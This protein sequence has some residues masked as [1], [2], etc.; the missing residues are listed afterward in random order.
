MLMTLN[1][2]VIGQ[3]TTC[4]MVMVPFQAYQ[5]C[6][7][8]VDFGNKEL[9][10]IYARQLYLR[11]YGTGFMQVHSNLI[12]A[13]RN[14]EESMLVNYIYGG[15]A[16]GSHKFTAICHCWKLAPYATICPFQTANLSSQYF[17]YINIMII[18]FIKYTKQR[19]H[20]P[21]YHRLEDI[22][23]HMAVYIRSE[24]A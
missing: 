1:R 8:R 18:I 21:K 5:T 15:T 13:T 20:H 11:R 7:L 14:W 16:Q 9:R 17:L 23:I 19:V 3:W 2:D 12:L 24:L 4:Q 10:R 6:E 22:V